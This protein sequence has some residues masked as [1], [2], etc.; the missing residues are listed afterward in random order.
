MLKALVAAD[1]L[2][3]RRCPGDLV[4]VGQEVLR[5]AVRHRFS[6]RCNHLFRCLR[7][8]RHQHCESKPRHETSECEDRS[9]GWVRVDAVPPACDRCCSAQF[10]GLD[11]KVARFCWTG[12]GRRALRL[13]E[14]RSLVLVKRVIVVRAL[15]VITVGHRF[16]LVHGLDPD[17]MLASR[18][19]GQR[20]STF[21]RMVKWETQAC[22]SIRM[23]SCVME[24]PLCSETLD[25]EISSMSVGSSPRYL[26]GRST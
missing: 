18:S 1:H 26:W 11:L 20:L 25:V 14:G 8:P 10:R 2:F 17:L 5:A 23:S 4:S 21:H 3:D 22:V 15:I 16:S 9:K 19:L 24:V 6:D 12:D 7:R 13:L